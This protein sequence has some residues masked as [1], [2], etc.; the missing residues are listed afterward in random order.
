MIRMTMLSLLGHFMAMVAMVLLSWY[1][2]PI[3]LKG[4]GVV[5]RI[6]LGLGG[7]ELRGGGAP[8][9]ITTPAPTAPSPKATPPSKTPMPTIAKPKPT[10][11]PP[12]PTAT[13][14]RT[15]AS[16]RKTPER[17]EKQPTPKPTVKQTPTPRATK[18]SP[19]I[20][21]TPTA[22]PTAKATPATRTDL[23]PQPTPQALRTPAP[24]SGQSQLPPSPL[25]GFVVATAK[26][27]SGSPGV[28]LPGLPVGSGG[29]APLSDYDYYRL[30]AMLKIQ[31]N[32]TI[33]RHLNAPGVTCLVVVN[34]MADGR[35]ANMQVRQSSGD[36][37]LDSLAVRA[38]EATER[39]LPL[40]DT[41]KVDYV[42]L[43][44]QFDFSSAE[45]SPGAVSP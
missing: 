33:P 30:M 28:G 24:Q 26:N 38:L 23:P 43:T 1:Q 27:A 25:E 5:A 7:G 32:F 22:P 2:P 10:P 34:V 11:P 6:N 31:S 19:K 44:I 35:I 41:L 8:L 45:E 36:P 13:P 15:I 16:P 12:T 9:T 18:A 20:E 40:P 14:R 39:L 4:P 37:I 17:T 29:G 21:P 42:P 3:R